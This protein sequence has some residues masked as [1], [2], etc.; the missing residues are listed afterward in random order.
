MKK[1][2]H[3]AVGSKKE[4]EQRTNIDTQKLNLGF[5]IQHN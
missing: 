2:T 4:K 3:K 1:K 5:H